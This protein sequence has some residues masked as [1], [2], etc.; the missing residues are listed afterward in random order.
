ML[1]LACCL[2]MSASLH[3]AGEARGA[4]G[5]RVSPA[6]GDIVYLLI[7][8]TSIH[9]IFSKWRKCPTNYS[10]YEWSGTTPLFANQTG[11]YLAIQSLY[12]HLSSGYEPSCSLPLFVGFIMLSSAFI[13]AIIVLPAFNCPFPQEAAHFVQILQVLAHRQSGGT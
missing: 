5:V 3:F 8:R 4:R 6:A 10:T 12:T 7:V 13:H 2:S 11:P 1:Q 9:S